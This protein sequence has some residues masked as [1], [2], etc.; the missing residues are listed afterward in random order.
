MNKRLAGFLLFNV[1]FSVRGSEFAFIC[2]FFFVSAGRLPYLLSQTLCGES[3][4]ARSH[5]G[6]DTARFSAGQVLAP[7]ALPP[8]LTQRVDLIVP[9][10][11]CT[12]LCIWLMLNNSVWNIVMAA[13]KAH[14]W[15]RLSCFSC[16]L[17]IFKSWSLSHLTKNSNTNEILRSRFLF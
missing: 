14:L 7:D 8:T 3:L 5:R 17:S 2:F 11:Y 1:L 15:P 6:D 4:W 13:L 9:P 10:W 12:V 16:S